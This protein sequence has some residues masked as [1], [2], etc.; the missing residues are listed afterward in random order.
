MA[1][2]PTWRLQAGKSFEK[3]ETMEERDKEKQSIKIHGNLFAA[4]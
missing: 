2:Q 1:S 4:S 3:R